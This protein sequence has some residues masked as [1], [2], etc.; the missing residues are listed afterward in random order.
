L[1]PAVLSM[2][3]LSSTLHLFFDAEADEAFVSLAVERELF[4]TDPLVVIHAACGDS[5]LSDAASRPGLAELS[6][7]TR[8]AQLR[9]SLAATRT[10][11]DGRIGC[12]PADA[13]V[14]RL[15]EAGVD[16]LAST[17]APNFGLAHGHAMHLELGLLVSAGLSPADALRAATEAP[18]RRF[19]LEVR[20]RIAPGRRAD[21]LLVDGDPTRDIEATG[22]IVGVWKAGHGIDLAAHRAKIA[23]RR[24]ELDALRRAP[25]PAGAEPGLVSDFDDGTLAIAFGAG[26]DAS[27]DAMI[28]GSSTASLAPAPGGTAG[29]AGSMLIAGR[30]EEH[31]GSRWAGASFV[32]GE[33]AG[34]AANLSAFER[35]ELEVR[36]T[37]GRYAL[38]IFTIGAGVLPAV[39]MFELP[40]NEA[41]AGRWIEVSASFEQ[42]GLEGWD[43]A[44]VFVGAVEVGEFEL[45]VDDVRFR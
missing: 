34:E 38:M 4:V 37:P 35:V 17:D 31:G 3:L 11:N 27:T 39:K 12:E 6:E 10:A 33:A 20:G 44:S 41:D 28:G 8:L 7:P 29:S 13:S 30:A 36:G 32:A 19:G 25:A 22:S 21:L 26:W 18:A 24:A 5:D 40:A 2:K 43:V 9:V 15:H 1:V 14:L 16:L 42:L 23:T 45:R